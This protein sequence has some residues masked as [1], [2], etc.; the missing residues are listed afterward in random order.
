VDALTRSTEPV[1][2]LALF[3]LMG[4]GPKAV[5]DFAVDPFGSNASLVMTNVI[6]PQEPLYLAGNPPGMTTIA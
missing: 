5:E 3:N 2:T 4:R 1:A 6:G